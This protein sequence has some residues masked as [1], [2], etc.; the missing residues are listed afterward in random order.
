MN[1]PTEQDKIKWLFTSLNK[2]RTNRKQRQFINL[3]AMARRAEFEREA[4]GY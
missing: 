1:N 4:E 2:L 3:L